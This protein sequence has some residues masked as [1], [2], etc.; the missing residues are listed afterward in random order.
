MFVDHCFAR[1]IL[2]NP[3][4]M[5][6]PWSEAVRAPAT[7]N[8]TESQLE[9]VLALGEDIK[10][11][12]QNLQELDDR[13][14]ALRCKIKGVGQK[15]KRDCEISDTAEK[16][17]NSKSKK[18]IPVG[19]S[20]RKGEMAD[21][22]ALYS[23]KEVNTDH[24][25]LKAS[26]ATSP[27]ATSSLPKAASGPPLDKP[28]VELLDI[29]DRIA[30]DKSLT[31]FCKRVLAMLTQVP[32]GRYTTY[33]A[34]ADSISTASSSGPSSARAVGSAMR[35]NP[36]APEV[37]CHRVLAADGKIGGFGGDWGDN[38]RFVGEKR[39]L[40]RE[41][42]VQFDGRGRVIGLPFVDFHHR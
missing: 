26:P 34:L 12:R 20:S 6:K 14:L 33:K 22:W 27:N 37:P 5:D 15:R 30:S 40:L 28:V 2:D 36:F 21:L 32:R 19:S 24:A 16:K 18:Q 8:M 7:K 4:G 29:R 23:A 25:Q 10:E 9:A 17:A 42:G 1:I 38:G 31:P 39:R 11:G 41:E 35:N 13:S 3:V